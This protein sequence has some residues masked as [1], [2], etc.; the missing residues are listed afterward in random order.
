MTNIFS[1]KTENHI[2]LQDELT[3]NAKANKN[4]NMVIAPN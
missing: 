4:F 3:K 1:I 2:N